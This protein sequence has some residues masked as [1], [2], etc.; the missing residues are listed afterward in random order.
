MNN[1]QDFILRW[2]ECDFKSTNTHYQDCANCHRIDEC[3]ALAKSSYNGQ[4]TFDDM[5]THGGYTSADDFW[6]TN[7]I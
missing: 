7:G 4:Q 2:Y 6:E 1:K 5:V 3:F